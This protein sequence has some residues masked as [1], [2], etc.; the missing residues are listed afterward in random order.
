MGLL[1]W[2]AL[3]SRVPRIG[4]TIGRSK[5]QHS[6]VRAV[7]VISWVMSGMLESSQGA[8]PW[9]MAVSSWPALLLE[10]ADDD[11]ER[12]AAAVATHV[13]LWTHVWQSRGAC[14][15]VVTFQLPSQRRLGRYARR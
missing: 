3:G 11:V 9:S 15:Q 10:I 4:E 7:H 8:P 1:R 2:Q 14:A 12:A 5:S 13:R 6:Y